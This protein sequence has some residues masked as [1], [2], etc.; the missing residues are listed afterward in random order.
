MAT[1]TPAEL[2]KILETVQA[3]AAT[4]P[5]FRQQAL[6]DPNAAFAAITGQAAPEGFTLQMI[7]TAPAAD[8]PPLQSDALSDEALDQVAGGIVGRPRHTQ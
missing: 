1:W 6:T 3:K 7:E 4:D 5:Q 8:L 2:E